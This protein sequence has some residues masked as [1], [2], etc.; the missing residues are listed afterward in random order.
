MVMR[1]LRIRTHKHD[2]D[3]QCRMPNWPN[4]QNVMA[5]PHFM[6][7]MLWILKFVGKQLHLPEVDRSNNIS[8]A[9][10]FLNY[11]G[12]IRH[13]TCLVIHWL[14]HSW[15]VGVFSKYFPEKY[16][17]FLFFLKKIEQTKVVSEKQDIQRYFG[18]F[19]QSNHRKIIEKKIH[20]GINILQLRSS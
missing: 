5:H 20:F 6:D 1:I 17:E 11:D 8:M 7:F 15:D 10:E 19:H 9:K 16:L 4:C 13:T 12:Q 3:E 14:I 18:N 2:V